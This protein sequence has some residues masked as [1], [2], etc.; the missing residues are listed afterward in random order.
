MLNQK[1]YKTFSEFIRLVLLFDISLHQTN[2]IYVKP[3][4][5]A[6][7]KK[8]VYTQDHSALLKLFKEMDKKDAKKLAQ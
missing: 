7:P 5:K 2:T 8:H 3:R 6:Y 1:K 4:K